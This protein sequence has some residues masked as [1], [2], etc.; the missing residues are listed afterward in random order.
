MTMKKK[1]WGYFIPD[2]GEPKIT[3]KART[4]V[5][6]MAGLRM[7]ARNVLRQDANVNAIELIVIEGSEA[8]L[9]FHE[10]ARRVN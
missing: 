6:V 9:G 8:V 4:A 1:F 5:D 2:K 3:P 10:I 7:E